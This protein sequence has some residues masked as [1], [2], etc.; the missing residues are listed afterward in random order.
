MAPTAMKTVPSGRL[1]VC[2]YG[3]LAVG[4]TEG[5]TITYAPESVG[6]PVGRA[7]PVVAVFPPVITG[8]DPDVAA[9]EPDPVITTVDDCMLLLSDVCPVFVVVVDPVSDVLSDCVAVEED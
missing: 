3:A 2:M 7:P 8:I 5:G 4:G 6:S 9:D 1:L